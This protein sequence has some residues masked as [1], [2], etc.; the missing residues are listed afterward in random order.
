M[1]RKAK[2]NGENRGGARVGVEG[3]DYGN[4]TD[5]AMNARQAA[6]HVVSAAATPPEMSAPATSATSP[7]A[8]S[9]GP[10]PDLSGPSRYP[11]RP[12]HHG[13]ST[14]PGAGPDA[15]GIGADPNRDRIKRLLPVWELMASQPGSSQS[16]RMFVRQ[17]RGG[18]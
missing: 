1:P 8:P 13:L 18:V 16:L 5:L 6:P 14:G 10:M 11:D 4:R 12:I 17:M 15:L 9:P 7:V 2:S 3:R